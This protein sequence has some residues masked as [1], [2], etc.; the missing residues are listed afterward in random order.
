MVIGEAIRRANRARGRL[1]ALAERPARQP[2]IAVLHA[3][4]L[5]FVKT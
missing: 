2:E 4:R 5:R 3:K 1:D